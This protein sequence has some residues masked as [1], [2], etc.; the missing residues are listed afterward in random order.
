MDSQILASYLVQK[1]PEYF[2]AKTVV[3]LGSGTGLVGL[4]V[5]SF[6]NADVWI[7]DQ[8]SVPGLSLSDLAL[9]ITSFRVIPRPLLGIMK[10]NVALNQLAPI[11][12]VAELNWFII[13]NFS[14]CQT[15]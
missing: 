7:T 12:Q 5:G 9:L 15:I 13:F 1:G 11:V 3:E 6:R 4:V 10:H 2:R 14:P 8:A